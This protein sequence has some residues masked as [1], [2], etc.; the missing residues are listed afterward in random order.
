M[1]KMFSPSRMTWRYDPIILSP[2]TD[3]S[4]HLTQFKTLA[5]KLAGSTNRC[6]ISFVTWYGKVQ[7]NFRNARKQRGLQIAEP[8][9]AQKQDFA[10]SLAR[11]ARQNDMDLFSCCNDSLLGHGVKK[12]ACIDG[13]LLAGLF[14]DMPADFKPRP[15]RKDC[16]CWES[17]DIGAYDTCAHACLYCYANKSPHK[18][19]AAWRRHDDRSAF[20]GQDFSTS[21]KWLKQEDTIMR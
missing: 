21:E 8:A 5:E 1:S 11:I 9:A 10:E 6:I 12:A 15:S 14:P 4:Y 13:R 7:R 16:G 17:A 20:L 18:A 3:W 19:H 2:D